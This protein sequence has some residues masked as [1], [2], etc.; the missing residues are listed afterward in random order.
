L[1]RIRIPSTDQQTGR[2]TPPKQPPRENTVQAEANGHRKGKNRRRQ[3]A[4]YPGK[5]KNGHSGRPSQV[6]PQSNPDQI[7]TVGFMRTPIRDRSK[8]PADAGGAAR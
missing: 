4:P 6:Q 7:S 8:S 2:P 1:I 3:R 5:G